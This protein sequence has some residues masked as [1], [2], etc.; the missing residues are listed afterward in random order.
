MNREEM[1]NAIIEIEG[2]HQ[3]ARG[4]FDELT[5]QQVEAE[6]LASLAMQD[7]DVKSA[8][9]RLVSAMMRRHASQNEDEIAEWCEEE[10]DALA[11]VDRAI[12]TIAGPT[13]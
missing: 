11:D 7:P 4:A 10:N 9:G 2:D 1:I 6:Y 5:D 8:L 3:G 12:E 13:G